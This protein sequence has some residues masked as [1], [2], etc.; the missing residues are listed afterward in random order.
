MAKVVVAYGGMS[1]AYQLQNLQE[2]CNVLVATPG[3]MM[4]L[5]G[6]GRIGLSKCKFLVLDEADRM[7]EMGFEGEVSRFLKIQALSRA[8][9]FL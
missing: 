6:K 2:G 9:P 7:L 1:V 4:D 8:G 5:I 3:R